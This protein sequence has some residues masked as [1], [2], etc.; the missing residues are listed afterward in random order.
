MKESPWQEPECVGQRAMVK[1]EHSLKI[2]R[3]RCGSTVRD[4]KER[5]PVLT[6]GFKLQAGL[7]T[8]FIVV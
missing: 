2:Q 6:C 5:K 8:S 3:N 7:W 1:N 4:K